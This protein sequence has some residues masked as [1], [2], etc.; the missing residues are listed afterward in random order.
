MF[1]VN[2]LKLDFVDKS[3]LL[4][5]AFTLLTVD[6]V[7]TADIIRL[8]PPSYSEPLFVLSVL[9]FLSPFVPFIGLSNFYHSI[10]LL[11]FKKSNTLFL[12]FY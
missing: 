5:R 4:A 6:T 1:L 2:G 8:H 7:I 3:W 9:Y 12:F 11:L 10:F